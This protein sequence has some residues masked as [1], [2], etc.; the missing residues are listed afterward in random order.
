MTDVSGLVA[1]IEADRVDGTPGAW[2]ADDG[3]ILTNSRES[4]VA[5][6]IRSG[7]RSGSE[8]V[9]NARRIARVPQM[10]DALTALAAE[11]A[12]LR[13]AVEHWK[14]SAYH[15]GSLH[16]QANGELNQLRADAD[17]LA[18][19]LRSASCDPAFDEA[20]P[21]VQAQIESALAAHGRK[22]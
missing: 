10:E 20:M 1:E 2:R 12:R 3:G 13:D 15:Q 14:A 8:A 5:L 22:G 9:A 16:M 17:A 19:A 11:N 18:G 4:Y 6:C 7:T 21:H